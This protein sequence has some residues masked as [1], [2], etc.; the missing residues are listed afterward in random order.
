MKKRYRARFWVDVTIVAE[1][2]EQA[3]KN[4]KAAQRYCGFEDDRAPLSVSMVVESY[5]TQFE[6]HVRLVED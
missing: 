6:G 4:A 5:D 1:N 3:K 2:E